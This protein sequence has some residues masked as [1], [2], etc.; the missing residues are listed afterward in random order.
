MAKF[1]PAQRVIARAQLYVGM[2]E[3]PSGSNSGAFVRKCQ[4]FTWLKGTGWPWCVAFCQRVFAECGF[5]LPWGSAGAWDLY[6]YA[7]R[8]GW[9]KKIPKPG[10]IAIWN[11]GTGH[12]S[13][14]R[15][16]LGTAVETIDGNV[17]D[18]VSICVRP[19]AEAR[20]F[21]RNPAFTTKTPPPVPKVKKPKKEIV[22]SASGAQVVA[23]TSPLWRLLQSAPWIPANQSRKK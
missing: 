2:H 13:I 4:S 23:Y 9:T 17:G 15:R 11:F 3:E 21:I 6:A 14:V 8:A 10:D 7:R 12:A 22:G 16:V 1:T 18:K 20:G 5:K 19:I